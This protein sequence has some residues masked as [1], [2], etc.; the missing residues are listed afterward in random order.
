[1]YD[2]RD[3]KN[4]G[5]TRKRLKEVAVH[6]QLSVFETNEELKELLKK[7]QKEEGASIAIFRVKRNR[8]ILRHGKLYEGESNVV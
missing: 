7:I 2:Y 1:V 5:K 3:E 8:K 6:A 4:R